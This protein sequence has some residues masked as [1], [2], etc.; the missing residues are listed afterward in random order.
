VK[1]LT[2]LKAGSEALL[3]GRRCKLFATARASNFPKGRGDFRTGFGNG[4]AT[5]KTFLG[6]LQI[7]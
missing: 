3:M 4:L 1:Q 7:S 6:E 2:W 5:K